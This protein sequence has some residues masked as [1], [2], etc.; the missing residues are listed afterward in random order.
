MSQLDTKWIAD[1]AITKEKVNADVAGGGIVQAGDGSL[2]VNDDNSTLEISSD[3][4]QVKDLGI[5]TAKIDGTAVTAAKLGVDVAGDGLTGGNGS[6]LDADPD[7]TGG[8]N[9]ARAINVSSNGIA[10]KVDDSTI[11]EN[12]SSRLRVKPDGITATEIDETDNYTW[13]GTH[14][15]TGGTI[16]G[17]TPVSSAHL[18]TKAYADTLRAGNRRK[19]VCRALADTNQTIS[20]LPSNIDGVTGWSGGDRI[21]LTN[22]GTASQNGIWETQ[23]SAWTRPTD[24]DTGDSASGAVTWIDAGTSYGET[25]WTCITDQPNDIIDTNNLAFVQSSGAGQIT[26]GTGLTKSGNTIHIGNGSTGNISGINRTADQI[27]AAVDNTTIEIASNLLQIKD[28]GVSTAKLAATSIT[29]AKLGA[30]VAGD[31]LTGGNGS[32]LDVDPDVAGGTNLATVV[33]V[34]SNGVAI[35]IDD[36]SIGENGSNQLEVKADGIDKTRINADVAGD[37][38]SQA[39]GG[40]LDL[41][42]NDLANTETTPADADL[43]ALYDQTNSRTEKI[44]WANLKA[45]LPAFELFYQ[46]MHKITAGET[47]AGYFTLSNAPANVRALR[48]TPVGGPMQVNKD[49]LD[50]TGVTADFQLL[51]TNQ[52]HFNNNGA[53][54]GLSGDMTTDDIIIVEYER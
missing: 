14:D 31:G 24:F 49:A 25:D 30:D 53:A 38:I 8:A 9:L 10:V 26:A 15:Y 33:N 21:L 54:S 37:G 39:A 40:E 44:T 32:D 22:Q 45:A 7:T 5:T 29:A 1:D 36:S 52:F 42:I 19:D 6:D 11:E 3:I 4:L 34:S 47:T 43:L 16:S 51:S 12:G 17:P 48:A 13:A 35:K 20:G 23:S 2:E 27:A 28:L 50:G 46:E 41:N 18:V